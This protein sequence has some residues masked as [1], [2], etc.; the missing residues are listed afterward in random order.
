[1]DHHVPRDANDSTGASSTIQN[2]TFGIVSA[3]IAIAGL[4]LTYLHYRRSLRNT[5]DSNLEAASRSTTEIDLVSPRV[6]RTITFDARQL[7]AQIPSEG[8]ERVYT[9]EIES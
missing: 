5:P 6:S 7:E 4:V 9:K 8:I 3:T 2:I 1:M